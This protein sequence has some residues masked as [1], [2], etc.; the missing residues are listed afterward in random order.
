MDEDNT[1][2]TDM[3][4][5]GQPAPEDELN[6]GGCIYC[7]CPAVSATGETWYYCQNSDCG[8]MFRYGRYVG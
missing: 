4:A 3:R 1:Q 5:Q 8:R 2:Q 7:Q 6:T